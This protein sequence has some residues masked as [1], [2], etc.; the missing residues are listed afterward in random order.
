MATAYYESPI[1]WLEIIGGE[2]GISRIG[3]VDKKGKEQQPDSLVESLSQLDEYFQNKRTEFTFQL[4]P[5]GTDFQKTVWQ[6]LLHIPF[7]RTCSYLDIANALG[8]PN[9]TRA[10]GNANGKNDIAI[11]IPCH[12]VVGSDGSLT[13]YAGGMHRKE[14]LLNFENGGVQGSLF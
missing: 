10:V 4:D 14:W 11:V 5:Q 13:G 9:S 7:G 8:D 2:Q 1:G 3:F 12:R 6:Q